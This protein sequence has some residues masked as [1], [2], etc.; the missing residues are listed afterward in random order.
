[1]FHNNRSYN[2]A[3]NYAGQSIQNNNIQNKKSV[4]DH[5]PPIQVGPNQ[6]RTDRNCN[7]MA[8]Q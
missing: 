2:D 1:M 3:V 6:W 4:L 7:D 5:L 8:Y